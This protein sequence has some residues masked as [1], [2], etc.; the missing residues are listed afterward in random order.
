MN[1]SIINCVT[2]KIVYYIAVEL[3]SPLCIS[4]GD[5]VLTDNDVLVNGK[6]I[7]FIP[8]SS[9]AGAMRGYIEKEKNEDCIFGYE[10]MSN[11]QG[12][13]SSLYVT[14][15]FFDG[16]APVAVRDGVAL[17]DRKTAVSGAKFD[18]EVVDTGA[19]GHFYLEL[20]IRQNDDEQEMLSQLKKIFNGWHKKEIRMGSKKS[21]GY[22]E[23]S[24]VEVK[25]KEFTKDNIL[26]YKYAYDEECKKAQKDDKLSWEIISL[27]DLSY[28][29][30]KYVKI[31]V[32]LKLEGGISI[33]KYAAKKGEPDFVHVTAN[34]KPV[35]PGTSFA[36]AI[37]H[38]MKEMLMELG[39]LNWETIINHVFGYVPQD[40]TNGNACISNVIIGEC[41][42]E[43][44]KKL[45]MVRNGISRFESGAKESALFKEVSYV[46]GT[47]KL[48]ILVKKTDDVSE[49]IGLLLLVLKDVQ[50]GFLP[51]GGQTAVG[52][53]L[54]TVNEKENGGEI[55]IS[56]K[57]TEEEYLKAAYGALRRE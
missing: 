40:G 5:G 50:N 49:I 54:F 14:D 41:V 8:G 32:P 31:T 47:T 13:M 9:L 39:A 12:R 4:K 20:V 27:S 17:S 1:G 37:R 51:V 29:C 43:G 30:S 35:I 25:K 44:A 18:M 15:L 42:L 10:D 23:I 36:G 24:L 16:A 22:G 46:G 45:T 2:K 57:K 28:D 3:A 55:E 48:E 19:K 56:F 7:P 53:G 33:R 11:H 52:R 21:R 6:G 34:G 38:R 26:Q